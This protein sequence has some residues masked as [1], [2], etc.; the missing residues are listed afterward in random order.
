[1]T[2]AHVRTT[3][4]QKIDGTSEQIRIPISGMT[5]AA[6]Q[7]HVQKTLAQQAGVIDASVNLMLKNASVTFDPTIVTPDNLVD[8]IRSTGYGRV[9][10]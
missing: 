1:M 9:C 6:C 5:C 10:W 7:S 4:D 3:D 2:A 8:A